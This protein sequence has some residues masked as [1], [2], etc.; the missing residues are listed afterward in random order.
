MF[1]YMYKKAFLPHLIKAGVRT[2]EKKRDGEIGED[3]LNERGAL[4]MK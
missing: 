1:I 3:K 2:S 4:N